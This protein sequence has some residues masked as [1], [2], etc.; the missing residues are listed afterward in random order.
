MRSDA[1]IE[2]VNC[3]ELMNCVT[4]LRTPKYTSAPL[5]KLFPFTVRLNAVLPSTAPLGLKEV[6]DGSGYSTRTGM[7]FELPPPGA[8][9]VTAIGTLPTF[10]AVIAD[11]GIAAVR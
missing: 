7:V 1:K 5:A 11:A 4:R 9:V 10:E 6:I 2:A 8:G 3:V